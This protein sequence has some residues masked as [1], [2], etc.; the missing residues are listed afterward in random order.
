MQHN[1]YR[2]IAAKRK[3]NIGRLLGIVI[4][5]A[6]M[7]T[8]LGCS[9]SPGGGTP[10]NTT[11]IG[12]WYGKF[13]DNY[14]IPFQG[15]T[16]TAES[17]VFAVTKTE[18]KLSILS[19]DSTDSTTGD[20]TTEALEEIALTCNGTVNNTTS[21]ILDSCTPIDTTTDSTIEML[22]GDVAY[23][24]DNDGRLTITVP[25]ITSGPDS[26]ILDVIPYPLGLTFKSFTVT[27]PTNPSTGAVITLKA[28]VRNPGNARSAATTLRFYQSTDKTI[29]TSDTTIGADQPVNA[30]AAGAE[31]SLAVSSNVPATA[32][33]YYSACLVN[34]T[35]IIICSPSIDIVVN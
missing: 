12:T 21:F 10:A 15:M 14:T 4:V 33:Y 24:F 16:F 23:D 32:T 5:A 35:A 17:V 20:N 11:L 18:G 30:R 26:I 3:R 31:T 27:T 2:L 9:E 25:A 29:D 28:T 8:L 6:T 22:F 19:G 1:G 7:L 34:G 13:P